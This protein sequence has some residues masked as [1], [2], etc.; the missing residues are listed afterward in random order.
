MSKETRAILC[1]QYR[2]EMSEKS[3]FFTPKSNKI[4]WI[5]KQLQGGL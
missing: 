4:D 1:E 5:L 3:G 2:K